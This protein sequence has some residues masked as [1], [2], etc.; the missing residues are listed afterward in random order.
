MAHR[1]ERKSTHTLV[2]EEMGKLDYPEEH[3]NFLEQRR[4]PTNSTHN[5]LHRPSLG[6][7]HGPHC[8][9]GR[10]CSL[11]C[12]NLL[13]PKKLVFREYLFLKKP[14]ILKILGEELIH[15]QIFQINATSVLGLFELVRLCVSLNY[16]KIP[17]ERR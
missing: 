1:T 13:L 17:F 12:T 16:E 15:F 2:F 10:S 5:V 3:I 7:K 11:H 6:I 8:R 14:T 9:V 4:K